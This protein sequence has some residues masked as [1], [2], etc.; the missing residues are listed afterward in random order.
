MR[1]WYTQLKRWFW[2]QIQKIAGPTVK[3]LVWYTGFKWGLKSEFYMDPWQIWV[4]PFTCFWIQ[5]GFKSR[6][7][8]FVG[9]SLLPLMG[10]PY[11]FLSFSLSL[12]LLHCFSASL[13]L[14]TRPLQTPC[15]PFLSQILSL[16]YSRPNPL[17]GPHYFTFPPSFS[18][19]FCNNPL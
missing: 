13:S 19:N 12:S 8:F 18:F 7:N 9:P 10:P 3:K 16:H 1:V 2:I 5:A 17:T 11:S 14:S 6:L 4:H 15:T